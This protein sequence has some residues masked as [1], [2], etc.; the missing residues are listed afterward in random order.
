LE[1]TSDS[2]NT[3]S[4]IQQTI[5]K[6]KE[7][8]ST[9]IV[10]QNEVID[11]IC[12]SIVTGGHVLLEGVPGLAKTLLISSFAKTLNFDYNRI[13]FTPDLM[14]ADILGAE[15]LEEDRESQVKKLKFE[16]GPIFTQIL[17]ADE[18]NR[19]P[20]KTQA[21]L[22]QAMQERITT[23]S[24]Q[25]YELPFPFIVFATQNPI[26]NEG[27]YPLPE[28]QLDRFM[29]KIILG[30]PSLEDERNISVLNPTLNKTSINHIDENINVEAWMNLIDQMPV[31]ESVIDAAVNMVRLS[32]PIEEEAYINQN[33]RWGAGPRASQYLISAAKACAAVNG[34]ATPNFE[35]LKKVAK[36]VLRHRIIP[37]FAAESKQ[38]SADKIIEYLIEKTGV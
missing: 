9:V 22:L 24:G 26:E 8:L 31:S 37:S 7:N 3:L 14:P 10:G 18:I 19:T 20:P 38:I 5:R 15:Y 23:I 25:N 16:K 11:E 36:P 12:L 1:V 2:V 21:A 29:F 33:V 27:T 4:E 28:A 13:Q 35:H 6:I 30:Y 17:L 34:E 32:R